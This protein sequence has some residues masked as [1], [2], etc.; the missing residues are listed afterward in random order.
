MDLSPS[1]L[2]VS[3]I[4]LTLFAVYYEEN[5]KKVHKKIDK[6]KDFIFWLKD[7]IFTKNGI[8]CLNCDENNRAGRNVVI[9]ISIIFTISIII[10]VT[11]YIYRDSFDSLFFNFLCALILLILIGIYVM[12]T[13]DYRIYPTINNYEKIVRYPQSENFS[14]LEDHIGI[15]FSHCNKPQD[16]IFQ[17]DAIALLI[18]E[19]RK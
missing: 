8:E 6:I 17:N 5:T 16:N 2:I 11:F 15:I 10:C 9:I 13:I 4:L 19:F 7:D 3:L 14:E 12:F 1:Y 18:S